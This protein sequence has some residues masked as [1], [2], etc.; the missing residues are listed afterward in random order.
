MF[1]KAK[2]EEQPKDPSVQKESVAEN[3]S[4]QPIGNQASQGMP[5]VD[6]GAGNEAM[7][8][9]LLDQALNIINDQEPEGG[10][11]LEQEP[12]GE[13][14]QIKDVYYDQ[15][16][17]KPLFYQDPEEEEKVKEKA[18]DEDDPLNMSM[19]VQRPKRRKGR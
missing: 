2:Q 11:L 16:E 1:P 12:E 18:E 8:A 4:L 17:Q 14:P 13:A 7:N 10:A 19:I 15:M 3:N 6:P 9:Q 5:P